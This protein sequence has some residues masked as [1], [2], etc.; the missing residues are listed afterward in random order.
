MPE[1]NADTYGHANHTGD[2]LYYV[3]PSR[4]DEP[5]WFTGMYNL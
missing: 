2:T 5:R 1:T 3:I 4:G